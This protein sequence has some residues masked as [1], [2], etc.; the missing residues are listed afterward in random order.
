MMPSWKANPSPADIDKAFEPVVELASQVL[1]F[2]IEKA[3]DRIGADDYVRTAINNAAD[4]RLI[5]LDQYAP[6]QEVIIKEAPNALF[7]VLPAW[8]SP[9][10]DWTLKAIPINMDSFENRKKL[11]ANW[12]GKSESELSEITGVS[13]AKF[14]HASLFL[15]IAKSKAGCLQLAEL[16]LNN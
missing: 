9:D 10:D 1:K 12:A 14:C 5:I 8:P 4:E 7:V 16:A 2:A 6:W 13:D 11:P 15:A 3:K